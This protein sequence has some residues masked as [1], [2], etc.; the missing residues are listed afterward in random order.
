MTDRQRYVT[1]RELAA[2]RRARALL[3]EMALES[4]KAEQA[5]SASSQVPLLRYHGECTRRTCSLGAASASAAIERAQVI[6][7][8]RWALALSSKRVH[9]FDRMTAAQ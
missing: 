8:A 7:E 9:P 3:E 2:Q 6:F 1:W 5:P 4:L